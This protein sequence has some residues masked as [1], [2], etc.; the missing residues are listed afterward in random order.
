VI[1]TRRPV[2]KLEILPAVAAVS[3]RKGSASKIRIC[4]AGTGTRTD[5]CLIR[6]HQ[7][8]ASHKCRSAVGRAA[9][10]SVFALLL[11]LS[12]RSLGVGRVEGRVLD[13]RTGRPSAATLLLSD[14]SGRPLEIEGTHSHVEYLGKQ[15]CYVEG[16]FRLNLRPRHLVVELGVGSMN[17]ITTGSICRFGSRWI[18]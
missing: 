13:D 17:S 12:Y 9:N 6:Y 18:R 10:G 14:E 5:P 3:L 16:V 1:R 2:C 7:T 11:L 4:A 15:R 8:V